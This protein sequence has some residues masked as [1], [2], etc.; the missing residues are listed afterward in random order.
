SPSFAV[1]WIDLSNG[2]ELPILCEIPANPPP[3]ELVC[4]EGFF[5][6][7]DSCYAV[8]DGEAMSWDNAQTFCRSLA[9]AGRLVEFETL[10]ELDLVKRHLLEGDYEGYGYWIGAEEVRDTTIFKWASSGNFVAFHDWYPGE[11]NDDASGDAIFLRRDDNWQWIDASKSNLRYSICETPAIE[12]PRVSPP[13]LP[14]H[15]MPWGASLDRR[16]LIGESPVSPRSI[17]EEKF[18]VYMWVLRWSNCLWSRMSSLP[19]STRHSK[20]L[21]TIPCQYIRFLRWVHFHGSPGTLPDSHCTGVVAICR[22]L[23]LP[24]QR[25]TVARFNGVLPSSLFSS[26]HRA[27]A[28]L[29]DVAALVSPVFSAV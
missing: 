19:W 26:C 18:C 2:T 23:R 28:W 7:G 17:E 1:E 25:Q 4:P 10:E 14:P 13:L 11:P 8:F 21:C 3:V 16:A 20:T 29:W 6:L 9:T 5:I 27:A 15:P 24:L 22:S 12:Y